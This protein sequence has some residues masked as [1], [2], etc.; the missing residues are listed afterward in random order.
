MS[1]LTGSGSPNT[2]VTL[3]TQAV[4]T[5]QRGDLQGAERYAR[6][7]LQMAPSNPDCHLILATVLHNRGHVADA[8]RH[9]SQS[10]RLK[11]GNARALINLGLLQLNTSEAEQAAENLEEAL[12]LV[13][14]SVEARH[15]YARALASDR[16]YFEANRQFEEVLKA[17]P[18][19]PDVLSGYARALRA[20]GRVDEALSASLSA[21]EKKPDDDAIHRDLAANYAAK[22]DFDAAE[23]E[24]RVSL[25]LAPSRTA[26]YKQLGA[27]RRLSDDDIADMEALAAQSDDLSSE[28]RAALFYALGVEQEKK[29]EFER[30]FELL[31]AANR[32]N[33]QQAGY[34]RQEK[35]EYF[36]ALSTASTSDQEAGWPEG[37]DSDKMIFI[38]GM[39]RSGTTLVEQILSA[40]PAVFAGGELPTMPQGV[41][42]LMR[43]DS[44]YT[45]AVES[46]D[47]KQLKELGQ[48]YLDRLP[49]GAASATRVTDKLPGNITSLP[50]IARMFP[51]ARI[52][53]CRRHPLDVAW[54]IFKHGF[55]ENLDFAT[56]LENIVHMQNLVCS[57]MDLWAKEMPG[58]THQVWYENLVADTETGARALVEFAGLDWDE[59]CLRPQDSERS[60][61]TA[62]LWQVRQPVFSTSVGSWKNFEGHLEEVREAMREHIEAHEAATA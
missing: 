37:H 4:E 46:L 58:R 47:A 44:R 1:A 48:F 12:K 26:A 2:L 36:E 51:N 25:R 3:L 11:P 27:Y 23:K 22:G 19:D 29:G 35:V 14:D 56:S 49:D 33:E 53:L 45:T 39:P 59:A 8:K 54:S 10:L 9:Y 31:S 28:D 18:G 32:I 6:S 38:V 61:M 60:V 57:F 13:P 5:I 40:H 55:A 43:D 16:R 15:Y 62:S 7:A 41:E 17:V 52:V 21:L 42:R 50:L 20:E 30:A 34:N 24:A